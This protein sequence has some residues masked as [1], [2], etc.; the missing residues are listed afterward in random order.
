MT[1]VGKKYEQHEAEGKKEL[2]T[3][4]NRICLSPNVTFDRTAS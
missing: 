3:L 1:T 4:R 2:E